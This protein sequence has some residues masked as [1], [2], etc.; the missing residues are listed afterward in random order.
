[1]S[2]PA[3]FRSRHATVD[4]SGRRADHPTGATDRV[5]AQPDGRFARDH[6]FPNP[7]LGNG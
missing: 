6:D 3:G 4:R 1:M 5:P 7:F 2:R